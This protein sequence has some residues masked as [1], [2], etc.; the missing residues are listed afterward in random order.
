[1]S[2][3]EEVKAR[4]DIVD[5]VGQSVQLQK[6]GR[7]FKAPC[8]FHAEKTPSFIVNPD[9]QTW[10]CFGACSTGGDVISFVMKREGIEFGEALRMLAERA[11]VKLKERRA[12]EQEDRA[13]QRLYE[14]NEA[15]AAYFQSRLATDAGRGAREYIETRGLDEATVR[16]FGLGYSPRGRDDLL[17]HLRGL[18]FTDREIVQAGLALQGDNGLRDRF[19]DRLMF[20]LWDARGRIIGFGARALDADAVPK[21]LNTAQTPLFDKSGTLYA[22]NKA[23][24][25][26]KREGRTVIVEG[27]MDV[28]AAHQHGYTNV[29]AQ[30]GTALTE[31]QY[32]LAKKLAEK[33]VLVLDADTAGKDAMQRV[34][35]EHAATEHVT[36]NVDAFMR[37]AP[38][39]QQA[40]AGLLVAALP[41]GKDPDDLIRNDAE[42]WQELIEG[43]RPYIDFW[44]ERIAA[45]HDLT[46]PQGKAAAAA[47][48]MRLV[49]V[50]DDPVIRSH[51]L[52]KAAR[53]TQVPED[54]LRTLRPAAQAPQQRPSARLQPVSRRP[55]GGRGVKADPREGFLLALLLQ[56]PHLREKG[57]GIDEGLLW[58]ADARQVYE[59]WRNCD[60]NVLKSAFPAEL[61]EYYE[62]LILWR[63][64]L[65][66]EKEAE[67]A[68]QDCVEKLKQ[69]RLQA[70]KQAIAA[71]IADLQEQI[72]PSAPGGA[73]VAALEGTSELG[74]TTDFSAAEQLQ[75]LLQRDMEIG[76]ELHKRDRSESRLTIEAEAQASEDG[77]QAV[78]MKSDG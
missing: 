17:G 40:D 37:H 56:W 6:A 32:R 28:I 62:R 14:A 4:L 54:E 34:A 13:R 20:P 44:L 30:M 23:A 12:S 8:P 48:M 63:L 65:S 19:R 7:A 55:T 39:Q 50:I 21:Y 58:E 75:E 5:V 73:A 33:I 45:N 27:Y 60:G 22:L 26:I 69:R 31:R 46:S 66:T 57:A 49:G 42:R 72:G 43:A 11:G 76:W 64:P 3:I 18:K 16:S 77:R 10:H 25:S 35:E 70:E 59:I 68:L 15:A 9:R 52:Q 67:E 51:Y 61:F 41:F 36:G 24:D 47:E 29:V 78:E 38:V 71:Q 53:L 2:E 1:M 74:A